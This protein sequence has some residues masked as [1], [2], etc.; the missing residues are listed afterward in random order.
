MNGTSK[1]I[2]LL[3]TFGVYSFVWLPKIANDLNEINNEIKIKKYF[4][5]AY[6]IFSIIYLIVFVA[7]LTLF[8]FLYVLPSNIQNAFLYFLSLIFIN[9]FIGFTWVV[10][11]VAIIFQI[12]KSMQDLYARNHIDEKPKMLIVF[13]L[14]FTF[15]LSLPFL[16]NRLDYLNLSIKEQ[17][18]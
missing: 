17:H 13:L 6:K 3:L 14:N 11:D 18:E 4:I 16:Q 5:F 9:N 12:T 10:I 15:L 1:Y 8:I 7:I 2:I